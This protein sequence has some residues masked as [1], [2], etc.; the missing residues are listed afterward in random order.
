M[1]RT[2]PGLSPTTSGR[3]RSMGEGPPKPDLE[4]T[5]DANGKWLHCLY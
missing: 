2:R 4:F 5:V 3:L 1:A